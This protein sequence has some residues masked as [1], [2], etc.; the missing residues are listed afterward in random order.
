MADILI[1]DDDPAVR[2]T[3]RKVLERA[4]HTIREAEDGDVGLRLFREEAP[5]LVITDLF[6]PDKDG[7]ETIQELREHAPEA[8]ILA[9][10][11]GASVEP[12]G[13]LSDAEVFGADASLAKPFSLDELQGKVDAL[14]SS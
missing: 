5:D 12:E 2:S 8:K 1:I 11:G 10:S 13:P 9:M 14:L 6:M 3:V 7:I 4:G